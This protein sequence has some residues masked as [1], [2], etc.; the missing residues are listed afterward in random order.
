MLQKPGA[1]IDLGQRV[2]GDPALLDIDEHLH[3][4][5]GAAHAQNGKARV[6]RLDKARNQGANHKGGHGGIGAA[7]RKIALSEHPRKGLH[8]NDQ[9]IAIAHQSH[10]HIGRSL[11]V[12][13][14]GADIEKEAVLEGQWQADDQRQQR[15]RQKA[16]LLPVSQPGRA[17]LIFRI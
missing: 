16:N 1:V 10:E 17:K 2:N 14:V 4:R 9:E 5:N 3:Q 15:Q 7:A 11:D 13:A 6:E 12:A 8:A